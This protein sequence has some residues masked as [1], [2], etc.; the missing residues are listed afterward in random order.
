M[1]ACDL[2]GSDGPKFI[3]QA[4]TLDGP[5][6]QCPSC[7]FYYV[8]SRRSHLTFGAGSAEE[9]AGRVRQANLGFQNLRLEEEHRLALLNA[10][11]RLN[12]I[13]GLCS[14][15]R[16]L[17]VGC[18]RGD[19]LS[20]ARQYFDVVGVEP[21][22]ELADSAR[23]VS[24]IHEGVIETLKASDFDVAASF[25]VIEH[26]DSPQRF[27]AEMV[28]RVRPGGR[29]VIETPNIES[30]PFKLLR[31]RWRQFIPEHYYF[32]GPGTIRRLMESN[33]LEVEQ[34][35]SVGKY[36]SV[37]LVL[38]RLSR[39]AGLASHAAAVARRI[40]LSRTTFRLNPRD[41]MLVVARRNAG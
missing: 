10:A 33:S 41:I 17:E 34:I 11:W 32:F 39:Y 12:I 13:R 2:C 24:S 14:S 3:L 22:P 16:L 5:L 37:E 8:G 25:H 27:L 20:V 23:H 15:G 6:V 30:L 21:N 31:S 1:M 40:G 4:K 7:H 26:V 9:V 35:L 18:A 36:A 28:R 19:F 38:N 29:V